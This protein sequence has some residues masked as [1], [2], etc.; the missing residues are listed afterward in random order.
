MPLPGLVWNVIWDFHCVC[1]YPKLV[2][3]C[4]ILF[5]MSAFIFT[6]YTNFIA[7]S[8]I[9]NA[10]LSILCNCS[11]IC[12][13]NEAG[14]IIILPFMAVPLIIAS[15]YLIVQS[16]NKTC[17][18]SLYCVARPVICKTLPF[19][20]LHSVGLLPVCLLLMCCA[21]GMHVYVYA[22][23]FLVPVFCMVFR[24]TSLLCIGVD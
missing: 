7:N 24:I 20:D 17:S 19:I 23:N 4:F 16:F 5:L 3:H 21:Y 13:W 9:F 18:T 14:M 11:S 6:Q 15:S 8:L 10:H 22:S 12:H 1:W 2:A